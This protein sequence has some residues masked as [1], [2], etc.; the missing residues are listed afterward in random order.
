MRGRGSV[1]AAAAIPEQYSGAAQHQHPRRRPLTSSPLAA[2]AA[3]DAPTASSSATPAQPLTTVTVD[4]GDRTYPIYIGPRLLTDRPDLLRR[5]IPGKRVLVVTNDRVAPLYLEKVVAALEA[6]PSGRDGDTKQLQVDSVVLPDGEAHKTLEDLQLVWDAA[7]RLR[8][9]RGVTFLALGGGVVGDMAGF[10]ASCYQRGVHFLQVPTTVMSQVDSSVGGKTGVNHPLGKNMIGAF[11]QPRAVLVDTDTLDTLPMRELA[12][13]ISEI[14][15]YGL[16]RDAA[17]FEW[18]EKG[19]VEVAGATGATGAAGAAGGHGGA[20]HQQQQYP[21][22]VEALLAR[23]PAAVAYAV[24][25]SCVNKAEVVAADE[26]ESAAGL[27]ATLNLGHTFGHAIETSTGY[28]SL[29]H[30]EAVSIG[31]VMAADMS[32]RLGWIDRELAERARKLL[33]RAKLPVAVPAGMTRRDFRE[34]MA[35]DK[36]VADGKLRLVLLRGELGGCVV[37]GEFDPS[38][39]DETLEA[40]CS[41]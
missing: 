8:L 35:V 6:P 28:G 37:T 30:G 33:E 11:Y 25:R 36:K 34:L 1:S 3:T 38:K 32:A 24:E 27:R 18:L 4:L 16:I 20:Q 17:L 19:P 23:D 10:A 26:R 21:G 22:G 7:L 15:K 9:D 31:M 29:L 5:H 14:V 2:A 13:G 41:E 12:S 40:F 39:L